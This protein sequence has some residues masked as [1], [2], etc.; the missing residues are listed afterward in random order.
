MNDLAERIRN[1]K[2]RLAVGVVDE[3]Y[4]D[5]FWMERFEKRGRRHS[6]EDLA[7]H[8][9]YVVQALIARDPAVLERYARWLQTVLTTRGMCSVHLSDSFLRLGRVITASI[10]DAEVAGKYLEVAADALRYEAGLARELQDASSRLAEMAV[11]RIASAP[12]NDG[13][14]WRARG[15]ELSLEDAGYHLAYLA[16]AL[17]LDRPAVFVDY[18]RWIDGFLRRRDVPAQHLLSML[19]IL[20][21]VVEEDVSLS[22]PLR[23]AADNLLRRGH[24]ALTTT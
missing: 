11:L 17:A 18:V 10:P 2:A 13:A 14:H 9:D 6:E 22:E 7:F 5:P 21:H 24:G 1:E 15:R 4:E 3:M 19:T 20:I 23:R 8:V 16:D 12:S